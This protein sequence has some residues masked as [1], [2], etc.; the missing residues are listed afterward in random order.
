MHYIKVWIPQLYL[1]DVKSLIIDLTSILSLIL[2]LRDEKNVKYKSHFQPKYI[3]KG[4]LCLNRY[5]R[6]MEY[7][8]TQAMTKWANHLHEKN[9]NKYCRWS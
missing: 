8:E 9:N 5:S 3:V 2:G 6:L 7:E 4:Q 1:K